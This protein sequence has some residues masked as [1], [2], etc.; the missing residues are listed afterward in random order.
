MRAYLLHQ[1]FASQEFLHL[2]FAKPVVFASSQ[3]QSLSI[4]SSKKAIYLVVSI[5][6]IRN[7]ITSQPEG[8]GF[9]EFNSHAAAE[10]VL[11]TY[12]GTQMRGEQT[13]EVPRASAEEAI[14]RMQGTMIGQ[15]AVHL[16]WGRSPTAKQD[17][18]YERFSQKNLSFPT[19]AL[20][21]MLY[22]KA[23]KDIIEVHDFHKGITWCLESASKNPSQ[24]SSTYY[25]YGQVFL[26]G[27]LWTPDPV[28]CQTRY[29]QFQL[30]Q[31][32]IPTFCKKYR[33]CLPNLTPDFTLHGLWPTTRT[34]NLMMNCGKGNDF[35]IRP[36]IIA[37]AGPLASAWPSI[38]IGRTDLDL[39]QYQWDKHGTCCLS[40]MT[41][42]N[43]FQ[44]VIRE[45]NKMDLL[46]ILGNANIVP[47]SDVSYTRLDIANAL[48][49]FTGV[50][51]SIYISCYALNNT[52]VQLFEIYT[53]FDFFAT[54]VI[55]CPVSIAQRG[56][57]GSIVFLP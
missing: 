44:S 13:L 40:R 17:C 1:I 33:G 26:L 54:Q 53:C 31:A 28:T 7:K 36:E 3:S 45:S 25:G 12:N 42:I 27:L 39:W 50:G 52:H 55:P 6:V 15:Q 21:L 48:T 2:E 29:D 46:S 30:V 16:S 11:Q 35:Y 56:C 51:N 47:R 49:Q 5:K 57:T 22:V 24:W 9:V 41:K 8:Y 32:W 14:Q 20:N 34:G 10:R 38:I 37:L 4:V 19:V 23:R 43:Y 18:L